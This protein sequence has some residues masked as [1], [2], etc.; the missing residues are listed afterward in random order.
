L[1]VVNFNNKQLY[2][3]CVHQIIIHRM[4]TG[5]IGIDSEQ[6]YK[7]SMNSLRKDKVKRIASM[8]NDLEIE[9]EV[10]Q[11]VSSGSSTNMISP[12][13]LD[14]NTHLPEVPP[15]KNSK[16]VNLGT[17]HKVVD[18][19]F[20]DADNGFQKKDSQVLIWGLGSDGKPTLRA[21]GAGVLPEITDSISPPQNFLPGM[22]DIFTDGIPIVDNTS[23]ERER[24]DGLRDEMSYEQQMLHDQYKYFSA[25]SSENLLE[26]LSASRSIASTKSFADLSMPHMNGGDDMF[27]AEKSE[28]EVA[29]FQGDAA[30]DDNQKLHLSKTMTE[31]SDDARYDN[32][33]FMAGS[34]IDLNELNFSDDDGEGHESEYSDGDDEPVNH[35]SNGVE[36]LVKSGSVRSNASLSKAPQ[37]DPLPATG[38]ANK[39]MAFQRGGRSLKG[40][41]SE[42]V[43]ITKNR[44]KK[45]MLG[46]TRK[47]A[48]PG[49]NRKQLVKSSGGPAR[50]KSERFDDIDLAAATDMEDDSLVSMKKYLRSIAE[51]RYE[52]RDGIDVWGE[53]L[54]QTPELE[55]GLYMCGNKVQMQSTGQ[56]GEVVGVDE[57]NDKYEIE[58]DSGKHVFMPQSD[59]RPHLSIFARDATGTIPAIFFEVKKRKSNRLAVGENSLCVGHASPGGLGVPGPHT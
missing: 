17:M 56:I 12:E 53:K 36:E 23:S 37:S 33:D 30:M 47:K 50:S 49:K 20:E 34:D 38:A 9:Q 45:G 13:V 44:N 58:L 7:K 43:I 48:L 28:E 27:M 46:N 52:I 55:P 59:L 6:E 10:S 1:G 32:G 11:L 18:A 42:N 14:V 4:I 3:K 26:A 8:S 41:K 35:A 40:A 51:K 21:V 29:G 31:N 25:A 19:E 39:R 57:E 16:I 24:M 54:H 15:A 22:Q 5:G 2:L